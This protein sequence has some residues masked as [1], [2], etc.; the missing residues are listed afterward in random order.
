MA[1]FTSAILK[2]APKIWRLVRPSQ[3]RTE[4]PRM[5]RVARIETK[6]E[7]AEEFRLVPN[8]THLPGSRTRSSGARRC[9]RRRR[10]PS[11]RRVPLPQKQP[12][13]LERK[14]LD[15]GVGTGGARGACSPLF[16]GG[17][18][19]KICLCPP[20]FQTQNLD[21][22]IEPTDICDVTLAWL[23]SRCWA[24]QM[25]P[26]HILSRSYAVARYSSV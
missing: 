23:A 6:P 21:L 17:G 4:G 9:Y 5:F 3:F 18:G 1:L 26:P 10:P 12:K 22:G 2:I 16:R 8:A 14:V 13:N 20:H 7:M 19:P 15:T 25:C 11:H 24:R